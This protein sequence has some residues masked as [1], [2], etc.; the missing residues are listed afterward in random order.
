MGEVARGDWAMCS[1]DD[2]RFSPLIKDF[3]KI[4]QNYLQVPCA[5]DWFKF[6]EASSSALWSQVWREHRD[7][8]M[9]C[10]GPSAQCAEALDAADA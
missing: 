10:C 2:V 8:L 6:D 1:A 4:L 9:H 7:H 3:F 5:R